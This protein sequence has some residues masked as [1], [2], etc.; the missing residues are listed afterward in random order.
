MVWVFGIAFLILVMLFAYT[1]YKKAHE[2]REGLATFSRNHRLG[3]GVAGCLLS[4][5]SAYYALNVATSVKDW[6]QPAFAPLLAILVFMLLFVALQ[7]SAML[8]FV[9]TVTDSETTDRSKRS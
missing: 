6:K 9:S 7:V 2:I 1:L 4:F 3:L 8:C 5:S